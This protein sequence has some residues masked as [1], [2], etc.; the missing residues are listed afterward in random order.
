MS[1]IGTF[2]SVL[3]TEP[4]L[5][6]QAA[7]V[8]A[9]Q[10]AAIDLACSRFRPDSELSAVNAAAGRI[11]RVSPLFGRALAA[12]LWA[13]EVTGGDV[14]PTCGQ[15][16]LGIGYDRDY[17]EVAADTSAP[18]RTPVP[19][20]GWQHVEF[21]HQALTVR[22]PQG[23]LLDFGATAKALAADLAA[24]AIAGR[25]G[26]GVLVN[27]GGDIATAGPPPADGWRVAV[28]DGVD[29]GAAN[30]AAGRET[31][32]D[33]APAVA[34]T[35]G[36]LATSSTRVRTW[37]QGGQ[38]RHHIVV[39]STGRPAAPHWAAVSVAAASCVDANAAST[40]AI[41]RG[42]RAVAWLT[43]IGLPARL[44]AADGFVL[45]TGGWPE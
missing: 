22:V 30:A 1:A 4:S 35:A 2:C 37:R 10:L 16:L 19:A 11:V 14:D 43:R 42:R 21:D 25:L 9:G 7:H 27:L 15:S 24:D 28:H 3:V 17:T 23:V 36:G 38:A 20:G 31:I 29:P 18:V 41:I 6:G 8:L 34:I 40:A 13:A 39:P 32:T 12:A 5:L 33:Q 44:A 26:C 45:T